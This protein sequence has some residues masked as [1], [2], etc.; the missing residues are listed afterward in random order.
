MANLLVIC[1]TENCVNE[2]VE[3]TIETD[4][5]NVACGPCGEAITDKTEVTE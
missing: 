4:S 3:I 1:H 5:P 2:N